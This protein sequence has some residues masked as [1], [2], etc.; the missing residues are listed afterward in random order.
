MWVSILVPSPLGWMTAVS[1]SSIPVS[2]PL[3]G[4]H[5]GATEQFLCAWSEI[6]SG[7][8]Q[9]GAGVAWVS[10]EAFSSFCQLQG[11]MLCIDI[12]VDLSVSW[13]S[14]LCKYRESAGRKD[15]GKPVHTPA[16]GS[17]LFNTRRGH[18]GLCDSRFKGPSLSEKH[19]MLESHQNKFTM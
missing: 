3:Q 12:Q 19:S 8:W 16:S 15:R 5:A 17:F 10:C 4:V 1:I 11:K 6:L 7:D 2:T 14:Q 13:E 18:D 9:P